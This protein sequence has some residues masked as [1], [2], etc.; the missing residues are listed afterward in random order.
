MSVGL[1]ARNKGGQVILDMTANISQVTGSVSTG[2]GNGAIT[3][4]APLAGKS[5][6]F[7]VVSM[8]GAYREKGKRPGVT[9]SGTT[10]SWVYSFNT[11]GWGYFAANCQIYYGY[12]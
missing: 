11:N 8:A 9:L 5:P 7:I 6:F 4:P 2:G 10:L 1:V 12:Y 3:I